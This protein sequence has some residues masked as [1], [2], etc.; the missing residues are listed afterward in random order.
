MPRVD[1]G[2]FKF[3]PAYVMLYYATRLFETHENYNMFETH[4]NF[5]TVHTG[6]SVQVCVI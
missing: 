4:E 1:V 2:E 6:N 3:V 5:N